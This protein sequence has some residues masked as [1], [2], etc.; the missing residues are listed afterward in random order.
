MTAKPSRST[1]AKPSGKALFIR[2][3]EAMHRD[4]KVRAAEKQV[5]LQELVVEYL[6]EAMKR[7]R[8]TGYAVAPVSAKIDQWGKRPKR[9]SR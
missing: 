8:H 9:G 2:V 5:S 7:G 1:E 4:L 6:R 3:P